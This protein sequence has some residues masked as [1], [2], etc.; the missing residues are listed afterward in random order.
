[1]AASRSTTVAPCA[2][3]RWTCC[4]PRS[5]TSPRATSRRDNASRTRGLMSAPTI[6]PE[7]PFVDVRSFELAAEI[8]PTRVRLSSPFVE[9]L[10]VDPSESGA[11]AGGAE[12]RVLLA[13]LYD[14][15][16]DD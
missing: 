7:S 6:Q 8:A 3:R 11:D 13:Q 14:E 16:L 4:S 15:T 5:D 10:A 12:R 2:R 9:A 1:M